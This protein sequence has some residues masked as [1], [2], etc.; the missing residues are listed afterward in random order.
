[1]AKKA[2]KPVTLTH[3]AAL[4][5]FTA[6]GVTT[7]SKWNSARMTAKLAK[8]NDI[9]DDDTKFDKAVKPDV[10]AVLAAI[11]GGAEITVTGEP[12][13]KA[14]AAAKGGKGKAPAAAKEPKPKKEKADKPAA[15]KGPPGVRETT[16]RPYIAGVILAKHGLGAGITEAMALELDEA[17]GKVNTRESFFCLRNAWHA[18]RAYQE[19]AKAK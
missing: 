12:E 16:T 15:P 13:G 1:M 5:I 19:N 2:A 7:A 3:A 11:E 8:L 18:I 9:I 10:D 6:L 17:Y 4:A 14:P